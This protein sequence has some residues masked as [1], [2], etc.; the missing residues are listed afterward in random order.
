MF[1]SRKGIF[2]PILQKVQTFTKDFGTKDI[3]LLQLINI[4]NKNTCFNSVIFSRSRPRATIKEFLSYLY[5]YDSLYFSDP[6]ARVRAIQNL[7][8]N[9]LPSNTKI[10]DTVHSS[11]LGFLN[12][13]KDNAE[14]FK[15]K[16][17][18]F[19][20]QPSLSSKTTALLGSS[21]K[22]NDNLKKR[23]LKLK[24]AL[25]KKKNQYFNLLDKAKENYLI[26]I[27]PEARLKI[28]LLFLK[29]LKNEV[30]P[31]STKKTLNEFTKYFFLQQE[32]TQEIQQEISN[33]FKSNSYQ[34][35][36]F[37]KNLSNQ[38]I[39]INKI[40]FGNQ[41]NLYTLDSNIGNVDISKFF[42][43]TKDLKLL[44]I[45]FSTTKPVKI[46][47][48]GKVSPKAVKIGGPYIVKLTRSSLEVGL[49][50]PKS[51]FG[52]KVNSGMTRIW[53]HPHCN[54]MNLDTYLRPQQYFQSAC[55]GEATSLIYNAFDQNSI[56]LALLGAMTWL[57]SANSADVWGKNYD[58]FPEYSDFSFED[59]VD[60]EIS[61]SEVSDFLNQE[62]Q[63]IDLENL[64]S[65]QLPSLE[66]PQELVLEINEP[67]L[68]IPLPTEVIEEQQEPEALNETLNISLEPTTPLLQ[69]TQQEQ[70]ENTPSQPSSPAVWTADQFTEQQSN[71]TPY[72]L[73]Y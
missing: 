26:S 58:T 15:V 25:E 67:I 59:V 14:S 7:Y 30:A 50:Q 11:T 9:I 45:T 57:T 37:F 17:D 70:V 46:Y 64:S 38:D 16:A 72:R 60:D 20:L 68:P 19:K 8:K 31:L 10:K 5:L 22:I 73:P 62:S 40:E 13:L 42:T 6:E 52:T 28:N 47:V 63:S 18:E 35:D 36:L 4:D 24:A 3:Y 33:S 56:K 23:E 32:T 29:I 51:F 66:E 69:P 34:E 53:I 21:P 27:L 48:D 12:V 61:S 54:T 43:E 2:V 39:I 71:Y 65:S 44:S 41:N 49:A 55:L 1:K